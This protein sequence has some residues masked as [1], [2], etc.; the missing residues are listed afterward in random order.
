MQATDGSW[1][2][3]LKGPPGTILSPFDV[4]VVPS[5]GQVLVVDLSDRVLRFPSVNDDT[6]I[7]AL[8]TGEGN[9]P[10][11]LF[12]PFGVAVLDGPHCPSV[13]SVLCFLIDGKTKCDGCACITPFF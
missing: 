11:D 3:D 10:T 9:G 4:A 12:M 6:V 8:G 13:R 1:V 5:T 7:D 2:R